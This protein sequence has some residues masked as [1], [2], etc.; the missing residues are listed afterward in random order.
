MV[1]RIDKLADL[2]TAMTTISG[3]EPLMHPDL[4]EI[5]AHLRKRGMVAGLLTNGYLL[6]EQLIRRLNVAG[7]EFL[8]ISI[9][10]VAWFD[11]W[12][13]PQTLSGSVRRS[14]SRNGTDLVLG[15]I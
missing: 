10:N 11:K 14:N 2:G 3:G 8:Q 9:D 1:R 7:V 13:H 15:L 6:T 5:I 4:D 12:R